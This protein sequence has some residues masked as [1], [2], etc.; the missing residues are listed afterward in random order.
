SG[1]SRRSRRARTRRHTGQE[2]GAWRDSVGSRAPACMAC[3]A[4]SRRR[5]EH[6][7]DPPLSR[8]FVHAH[9]ERTAAMTR[10]LPAALAALALSLR[11]CPDSIEAHTPADDL[12]PAD[13]PPTCA[14][15]PPPP[16]PPALHEPAP[17]DPLPLP[18]DPVSPPSE[19]LPPPADDTLDEATRPP[20]VDP[21][22]DEDPPVSPADPR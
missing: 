3:G 19:P 2:R 7:P 15:G 8:L 20:P 5:D 16:D 9:P 10:L 13:A 22:M 4:R 1:W 11:V 12:P 21:T 14:M 6:A 17:V 18:T